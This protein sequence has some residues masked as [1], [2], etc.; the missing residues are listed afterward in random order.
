KLIQNKLVSKLNLTEYQRHQILCGTSAEFQGDERDVVFL[1]MIDSNEKETG[2]IR[3]MGAPDSQPGKD[4]RRRYNVAV[5]RAKDQLWVVN[6]LDYAN[7]LQEGDVR[8]ELLEY[9]SNPHAFMIEN[10]KIEREAE[11]PF[12][13]EVA[14]AL[15]A[16][17]YKLVQ[18]WPVGAYRI[19][20]VAIDGNRKVAIEC[21]GERW[22]SSEEQIRNDME[23]QTILERL[24][25]HFVRLRG[26][27][28]YGDAEA[29]IDR[30]CKDLGQLGINPNHDRF[31][32]QSNTKLLDE[33]KR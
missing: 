21:D 31:E 6:S 26:S 10:E 3:K 2:P 9:A 27:E 32:P 8:K 11:S 4:W 5:S 7:D 19:D 17:G 13:E 18:Q 22:H 20:M 33:L 29:A 1:S 23:R 14:K 16:R 24:G 12:E 15:A 30:V 28:Y 25:W